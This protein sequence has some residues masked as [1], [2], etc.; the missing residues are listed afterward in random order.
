[1][2]SYLVSLIHLYIFNNVVLTFAIALVFRLMCQYSSIDGFANDWH[3]THLVSR[4]IG[5]AGLI[6]TEAVAVE[7]EGRISPK[8]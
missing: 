4:A 6:F 1:M 8:D 3:L 2:P 5:G 7:T